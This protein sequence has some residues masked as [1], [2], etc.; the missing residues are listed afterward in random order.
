MRSRSGHRAVAILAI[1]AILFALSLPQAAVAVAST[2]GKA[3]GPALAA[4]CH[5]RVVRAHT[6]EVC[7]PRG[8]LGDPRVAGGLAAVAA[9]L[10][11]IV[12]KCVERGGC[13]NEQD[14]QRQRHSEEVHH[15]VA[16]TD[17]RAT[18]ARNILHKVHIGI[19][20]PENL[21]T[22]PTSFH[23]R[24]GSNAYYGGVNDMLYWAYEDAPKNFK[25]RFDHVFN[26]LFYIREELVLQS[27]NA[28][29]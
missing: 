13:P 7:V 9:A 28:E 6:A 19:N 27:R 15:I 23:R 16:Q 26:A 14:R 3:S 29:T 22:L 1:L 21:V 25:T 12:K 17:R 24:L 8:I 2:A 18:T 11:V 4:A 20:S 5:S 10:G